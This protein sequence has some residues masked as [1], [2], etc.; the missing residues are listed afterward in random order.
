MSRKSIAFRI[1]ESNFLLGFILLLGMIACMAENK[2]QE[3]QSGKDKKNT[4]ANEKGKAA[5]SG[6]KTILF[7]GNSLTAGYGLDEQEAFPALIQKKIDSL[8][9]NYEVV[10]AGNSGETTAGGNERI[11]WILKQK[12]DVFVLELGGNDGLRGIATEETYKNLQ[13]IIGKVKNAY[14]GIKIL[15]TGME[16][17]PNMGQKYATEFRKIF[18]TLAEKNKVVLLPFLLEGVGGE[19]RLNQ[20][21]G[22]HPTA[23]GQRIVA[24]NVWK[25]LK[26]L[27]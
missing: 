22:I 13:E 10:N 15:L 21:D 8:Q 1:K 16:V 12:I 9:L 26:D 24:E 18:K 7:F 19:E 23:E 25:M 17:P 20:S 4:S 5:E 2:K 27:L 11:N 3:V 6:K 14:P